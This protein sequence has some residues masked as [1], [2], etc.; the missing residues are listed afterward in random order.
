MN[1]KRL[2]IAEHSDE[3]RTALEEMLADDFVIHTARTGEEAWLLLQQFHPDVLVLD[4]MLPETD[5]ITLLRRCAE[6]EIYPSVLVT[7]RIYSDYIL[8]ALTA[9][10]VSYILPKP[11]QVCA[12]AERARELGSLPILSLPTPRETAD[13]ILLRLGFSQKLSGTRYLQQA[14]R[15]FA[16]DPQQ[17]LTKELYAAVG[18]HFHASAAQVERCI[19]N[20]I[21]T[22]WSNRDDRVWLRYFPSGDN[23]SVRRPTNGELICRLSNHLF[24]SSQHNSASYQIS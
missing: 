11:C 5:G 19:R 1:T 10:G 8:N 13:N 17:M 20:A 24:S 12:V 23:G 14:I 15:L 4:V 6:K 7:T 16:N 3:F 22:A 18:Q 21:S 9:L 2:L